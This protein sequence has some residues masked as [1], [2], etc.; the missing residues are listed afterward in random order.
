MS[1]SPIQQRKAQYRF[2]PAMQRRRCGNCMYVTG[3]GAQKHP[4]QCI[5]ISC[6]VSEWSV[7][8]QHDFRR[9]HQGVTAAKR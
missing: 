5:R 2:T 6:M 1:T 3:G 8:E 4:K 7:C 9:P